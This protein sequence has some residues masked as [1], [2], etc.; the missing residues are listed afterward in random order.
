MT[1]DELAA[2]QA[3]RAKTDLFALYSLCRRRFLRAAALLELPRDRLGPIAA[4]GGWEPVELAPLMP[5]WSILCRRY[6][7]EGYDPQINLFAPSASTPA[8]AW[9]HFVHHR[10]FPTLAQDDELVRNVLRAV[11]AT[12]CR[13][14]ANAAEALCLR[15]TEMTLSDTPSPWAPEEDIQ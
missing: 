10:L 9:S 14:S 11:G 13:S 2:F 7:E 8:E 3:D 1:R 6:R 4:M 12:P 5:A 15:L